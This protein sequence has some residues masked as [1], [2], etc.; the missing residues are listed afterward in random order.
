[1]EDEEC[2]LLVWSVSVAA[3]LEMETERT[4]ALREESFL[5]LN[6]NSEDYC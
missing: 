3:L 1:M 5:L 4:G 2:D 6:Y